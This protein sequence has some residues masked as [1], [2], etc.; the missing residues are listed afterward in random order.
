MTEPMR[1]RA[2]FTLLELFVVVTILAILA[3][4][5]IA[6][7]GES[8]RRAYL[9]SMQS[10]LRGVATVAETQFVSENSYENVAAPKGS[11]G[12][13]VLFVGTTTG[14]SATATH[15]GVPGVTCAIASGS[16]LAVGTPADV[17]CQ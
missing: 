10:D 13:T 17:N 1:R 8:K 3:T 7:F 9:T 4:I 16:S 14:W 11:E 12:V 2:G 5:A 15:P 6:K